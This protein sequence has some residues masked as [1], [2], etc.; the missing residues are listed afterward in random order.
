MRRKWYGDVYEAL[1]D[2]HSAL[3][4]DPFYVKAHFRLSRALLELNQLQLAN[5]CLQELK[6]RFPSHETNHGVLMLEQDINSALMNRN[7]TSSG[8]ERNTQD[9][10]DSELVSTLI[11]KF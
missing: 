10:S 11:V 6:K 2:C 1:R 8:P 5:D 9:F 7:S 3:K 4:L